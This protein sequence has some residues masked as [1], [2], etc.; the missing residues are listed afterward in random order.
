MKLKFALL[1]LAALALLLF[2]CVDK[3]APGGKPNIE[4]RPFKGGAEAKVLIV[5]FSD[6]QCPVCG[7]AY[8]INKAIVSEYGQRIKFVY[9]H[10]PIRSIHPFAQKAAEAS[11]CAGAQNKFWEMHDRMFENNEALDVSSLKQYAADIGLNTNQFNECLDSGA[12]AR[13]VNDDL[14]EGA[15]LGV[16]ATPT[17]WVNGKW[18]RGLLNYDQFKSVIDAELQKSSS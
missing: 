7:R 15:A 11:E 17:F 4:G 3:A 1:A 8:P 13:I 2:G 12:K 6:F 16:D 10:F 18:Y 9:K 14:G 5:E